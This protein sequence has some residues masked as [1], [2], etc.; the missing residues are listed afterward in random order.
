MNYQNTTRQNIETS[1]F[2]SMDHAVQDAISSFRFLKLKSYYDKKT[3]KAH[4]YVS[5]HCN[6]CLARHNRSG[7]EFYPE[8]DDSHNSIRGH[9]LENGIIVKCMLDGNIVLSRNLASYVRTL[10]KRIPKNVNKVYWNDDSKR[11]FYK[12]H[13]YRS[14]EK[15]IPKKTV[16]DFPPL[17]NTED[18]KKKTNTDENV[19]NILIIVNS[20]GENEHCACGNCKTVSLGVY[21]KMIDD[22]DRIIEAS[23]TGIATGIDGMYQRCW[24]C[25]QAYTS[26]PIAPV[27][28]YW[29]IASVPVPV[30]TPMGPQ[31]VLQQNFILVQ[32]I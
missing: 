28:Y 18:E 25:Q 27:G 30:M 9:L 32:N 14:K 24:E 15:H 1:S 17:V 31:I 7:G 11:Y 20:N 16:E 10:D 12:K 23:Q 22:E 13:N 3:R 29:A 21:K 8:C 4:A 19:H 2:E 6:T 5:C 26:Q